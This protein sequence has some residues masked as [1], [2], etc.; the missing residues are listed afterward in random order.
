M[1]WVCYRARRQKVELSIPP[2]QGCGR[3]CHPGWLTPYF[4][5]VNFVVDRKQI[6]AATW[7]NHTHEVRV[8]TQ[9]ISTYVAEA[10]TGVRGYLLT[11]QE[12]FL[13]PYNRALAA[14][15]S[16]VDRLS[17]LVQDNPVQ[18][19]SAQ[20][21]KSLVDE[22]LERLE[23]LRADAAQQPRFR[24]ENRLV[25]N[26]AVLDKLR[27]ELHAMIAEEGR[28]LEQRTASL[29]NLQRWQQRTSLG[30]FFVGIV[31]SSLAMLLFI[32]GIVR[33]VE[34]VEANAKRLAQGEALLPPIPGG[35][36][37]VNLAESWTRRRGYSRRD[38]T[39]CK[40]A[41]QDLEPLSQMPRS[42]FKL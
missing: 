5:F 37:S 20:S 22:L 38:Q 14:L 11:G 35:E 25:S 10:S 15:P 33:R 26:K 24:L 4:G 12:R 27:G 42:S 19:V 40:R 36:Y 28:L 1:A 29:L 34:Y 6:E 21:V 16:A 30:G 41:R 7:V 2:R 17:L 23:A 31:G 18:T 39:S 9:E 3:H 13:D 8:Q 32:K